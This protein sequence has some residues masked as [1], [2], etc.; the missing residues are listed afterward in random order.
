M[1]DINEGIFIVTETV[2]GR[3]YEIHMPLSDL[4]LDWN[5]ECNHVPE[6]DAKVY[7]AA[8]NGEP[9]N[10][11]LYTDFE[12]L[13]QL[14]VERDLH[15]TDRE[16]QGMTSAV[17][18]A[19][20][21]QEFHSKWGTAV[22]RDLMDRETELA[23]VE[24]LYDAYEKS[25]FVPCFCASDSDQLHNGE[26]FEVKGRVETDD[27]AFDL[28]SLPAWHIFFPD[29][30]AS[31][32]AFPEEICFAEIF[33]FCDKELVNYL[34]RELEDDS[35]DVGGVS[36]AGETVMDFLQKCD[37]S[38]VTDLETLNIALEAC[39]IKPVT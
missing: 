2:D 37:D 16:E 23:F 35:S 17:E 32:E 30:N 21:W 39:G 26:R 15:E 36:F 34:D 20:E 33:P 31:Y 1:K 14:L 38:V 13:L 8:V 29:S 3:L 12:N 25:G 22:D 10:P 5:G 11:Y 28:E 7:F 27:P 9:V 4:L 24:D 19:P 18:I 6:N